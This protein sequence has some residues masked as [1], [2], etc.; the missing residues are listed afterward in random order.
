MSEPRAVAEPDTDPPA[1]YRHLPDRVPP[2][3]L[4]TEQPASGAPDPE[5]GRDPNH[6]WLL[7]GV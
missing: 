1:G 4:I 5:M 2:E 6:D 7:R 3:D